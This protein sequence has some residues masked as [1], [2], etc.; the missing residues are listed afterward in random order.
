MVSTVPF[1]VRHIEVPNG[2]NLKDA[3]KVFT[4]RGEKFESHTI[5]KFNF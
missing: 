3:N 1:V 4:D 5:F 2:P